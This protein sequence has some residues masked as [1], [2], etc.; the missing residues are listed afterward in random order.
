MHGNIVRLPCNIL[1]VSSLMGANVPLNF[2]IL[3]ASTLMQADNHSLE[4]PALV[5]N[6]TR[7]RN[8]GPS[9]H[10]PPAGSAFIIDTSRGTSK[11]HTG[12]QPHPYLRPQW[13]HG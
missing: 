12:T 13:E 4:A 11:S 3:D 1:N 2:E 8:H 7:E 9:W 10:T 6:V 5:H